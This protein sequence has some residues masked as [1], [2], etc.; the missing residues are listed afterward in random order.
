MLL[1]KYRLETATMKSRQSPRPEAASTEYS[2][3]RSTL[4]M[5][6]T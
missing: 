2:T 6:V 4:C 3:C 1:M 5:L